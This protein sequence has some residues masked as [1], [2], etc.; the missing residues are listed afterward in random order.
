ME[1]GGWP[2]AVVGVASDRREDLRR[3]LEKHAWALPVVL[4]GRKALRRRFRADVPPFKA[5]LVGAETVYRDDPWSALEERRKE[6]ERCLT[7]IFSR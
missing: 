3:F 2:V 5:L 7:R 4:D 1:K 6:L